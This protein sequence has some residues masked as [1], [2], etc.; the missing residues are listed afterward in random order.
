MFEGGKKKREI[1]RKERRNMGI[2][3]ESDTQAT[4]N[5]IKSCMLL[6][7]KGKAGISRNVTIRPF[8]K[9]SLCLCLSSRSVQNVPL[10]Q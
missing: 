5:L 4:D 7:Q 6:L 2:R 1:G 3:K 10:Q 9:L 8:L